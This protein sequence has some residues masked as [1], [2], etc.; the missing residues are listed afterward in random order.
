MTDQTVGQPEVRSLALAEPAQH[1]R[2]RWIVGLT[3]ASLG[4][5]MAT[6]TPLQ[7]M[8]ALQLQD[9][10]PRHK[11]VALGVVTGIGAISSALATPVVGALSDRTAHGGRRGRFSG[12]RHRRTLAMAILAAAS[13]VL[14]AKQVTV[15]GTTRG[16]SPARPP[17]TACSS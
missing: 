3:L 15:L 7:V 9:I 16:C 10:T 4:M 2:Y 12:R 6:Q 1:V 17:R 14:L 8:L 11:I 5:W 13:M